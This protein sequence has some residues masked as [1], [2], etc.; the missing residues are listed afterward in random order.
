MA[1]GSRLPAPGSRLPAAGFRLPQNVRLMS[2][3]MS[4]EGKLMSFLAGNSFRHRQ[5]VRESEKIRRLTTSRTGVWTI[6]QKTSQPTRRARMSFV[7]SAFLCFSLSLHLVCL[8]ARHRFSCMASSP[9]CSLV[10]KGSH[11]CVLS[12]CQRMGSSVLGRSLSMAS[13][14][15]VSLAN[16]TR[17]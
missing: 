17:Y 15:Y 14:N 13:V 8:W 9:G 11:C 5:K 7:R 1:P 10:V 12:V 3:R 6:R 2:R 4:E 16:I